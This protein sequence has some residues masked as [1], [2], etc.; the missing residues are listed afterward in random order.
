M[1]VTVHEIESDF[2]PLA[3]WRCPACY[4]A[5]TTQT[6]KSLKTVL[7]ADDKHVVKWSV[8]DSDSF[9]FFS[10]SLPQRLSLGKKDEGSSFCLTFFIV[11]TLDACF[12][13]SCLLW[14]PPVAQIQEGVKEEQKNHIYIYISDFK[15]RSW[16]KSA[17]LILLFYDPV[18]DCW[19]P[20]ECSFLQLWNHCHAVEQERPW[21]CFSDLHGAK[22]LITLTTSTVCWGSSWIITS[23]SIWMDCAHLFG[24]GGARLSLYVL[25]NQYN[26]WLKQLLARGVATRVGEVA[27]PCKILQSIY[28][29]DKFQA[30]TFLHNQLWAKD[31]RASWL[32]GDILIS[33]LYSLENFNNKYKS[34]TSQQQHHRVRQEADNF[35]AKEINNIVRYKFRSFGISGAVPVGSAR[36]IS[37]WSTY[38]SRWCVWKPCRTKALE[39]TEEYRQSAVT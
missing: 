1:S 11:G 2:F 13:K 27:A 17:L 32:T 26:R 9:P 34:N 38:V 6:A 16:K 20:D 10:A 15:K 22:P 23:Q 14:A 33:I 3:A 29:K 4:L 30:R 19:L 7:Q 36:I 25:I 37:T 24:G 28:T 8:I 21:T 12:S 31:D 5:P 35:F 18:L 39:D